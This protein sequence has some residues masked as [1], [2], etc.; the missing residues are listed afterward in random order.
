[1]IIEIIRRNKK[2][3][4]PLYI[5]TL[6][7][8]IIKNWIYTN[9]VENKYIDCFNID[10]INNHIIINYINHLIKYIIIGSNKL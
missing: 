5:I 8:K 6:K 10:Y 1:M 3:T 4:L 9:L 7:Q 2:K